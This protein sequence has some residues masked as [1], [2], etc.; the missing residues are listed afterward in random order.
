[1]RPTNIIIIDTSK[2][3]FL[4]VVLVSKKELEIKSEYRDILISKNNPKIKKRKRNVEETLITVSKLS[5]I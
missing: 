2:Y 5:K 1:M 4:V 3:F